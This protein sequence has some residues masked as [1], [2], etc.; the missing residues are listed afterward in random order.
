[1]LPITGAFL[2]VLSDLIT[3]GFLMGHILQGSLR[4]RF[5][6]FSHLTHQIQN[7]DENVNHT[8]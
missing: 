7:Q 6:Q 2:K 5:F 1:M 3:G 8:C 4:A